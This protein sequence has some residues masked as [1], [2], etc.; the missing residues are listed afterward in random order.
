MASV[1]L[2]GTV[3]D[4]VV[5]G[6]GW[7]YTVF[8]QGCPHGCPGCH[9]PGTHDFNGGYEGD[10]DELLKEI[11]ENPLLEGI[12]LSGGEPF[13]QPQPLAELAGKVH[14]HNLS[15]WCYT[16]YTLEQLM[17]SDRPG[18]SELLNEI[19]VLVDGPFIESERD[20][21]LAFRGSRN[22]RVIDMEKTRKAGQV[23][24]RDTQDEDY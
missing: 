6:E 24:L 20:L 18:V 15:V 21:T 7:R 13:C 17:A 16:G 9:N 22:Q 19:D 1:K 3:N 4:S 11:L 10:T 2:S 5:D 8:V 12:T 14:E 23:V